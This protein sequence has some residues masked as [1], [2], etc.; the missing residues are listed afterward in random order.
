[1]P[2]RSMTTPNSVNTEID[3]QMAVTRGRHSESGQSAPGDGQQRGAGDH[4]RRRRPG[5]GRKEGAGRAMKNTIAICV[6]FAAVRRGAGSRHQL[7]GHGAAIT[8]RRYPMK[9]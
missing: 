9:C 5:T 7:S 2:R 6:C 4:A 3:A 8:A 1:M